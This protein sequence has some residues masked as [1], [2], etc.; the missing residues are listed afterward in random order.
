MSKS[1]NKNRPGSKN[2]PDNKEIT[3]E[4][5]AMK[6]KPYSKGKGKAQGTGTNLQNETKGTNKK[7]EAPVK[8]SVI[9]PSLNV[10]DYIDECISSVINQTLKDIEII[11][12]D[13]GSTDG[14]VDILRK[15]ESKD[16]RICILSSKKKSYG[17]Q[18][19]LGFAAARGEYVAIVET[20]DYIKS[21]MYETLYALAKEKDLDY[22]K[23]NFARFK[24]PEKSRIFTHSKIV[25]V[26]FYDRVLYAGDEQSVFIT[27][28]YPWAGIYRRSMI[29]DNNIRLNETPGASYQDNGLVFQVYAYGQRGYF[30]DKEFYYLRRED[31]DASFYAPHKVDEIFKEFDFVEEF[32]VKSGYYSIFA[33]R[34]WK[35]KYSTFCWRANMLA[36]EHKLEFM[37]KFADEFRKADQEGRLVTKFFDKNEKAYLY[38]IMACPDMV[39]WKKYYTPESV[40]PKLALCKEKIELGKERTSISGKKI[41]ILTNEFAPSGA[42][43]SALAQSK[44]LRDA[45]AYVEA[46]SLRDGE[47]RNNYEEEG[48]KTRIV[49]ASDYERTYHQD[50]IK[51]FDLAIMNTVLALPAA[52]VCA[53]LIPTILYIRSDGELIVH[54]FKNV[55]VFKN[56]YERYYTIKNADYVVAVSDF[57]GDWVRENLN[58]NVTVINN[59]LEDKFEEFGSRVKSVGST[60]TIKFLALGTI[61]K[62]KGYDVYLDAYCSLPENYRKRCEV[63]FAGRQLTGSTGFYKEITEKANKTAG[64]IFH[65]EILDRDKLYELILDSDVIVV[66]SR[67][68]SFS[69]VAIEGAMLGKP[70]ILT[71]DVGAKFLVENGK[72][73]WIVKTADVKSLAEAFKSA[74]DNSANLNQMGTAARKVYL[75]NCTVE[76]YSNN[77][78]K[79]VERVLY[80]SEKTNYKARKGAKLYSF[81]VFDTLVTRTVATPIGLFLIVQ[82][83]LNTDDWNDLPEHFRQNFYGLRINAER[84]ARHVGKGG[85]FEKFNP[86]YSE[87]EDITFDEIYNV[88]TFSGLLTDEQA[89]RVKELEIQTEIE[90]TVAISRNIELAKDLMKNGIRVIAL[91]DMYHSSKVIRQMLKAADPELENIPVYVSSEMLM[92]KRTGNAFRAVAKE[93]KVNFREWHHIGDNKISDFEVPKQLGIECSLYR[94]SWPS[95][96]ESNNLGLC[97]NDIKLQ[98]LAALAKN[99]RIFGNLYD[100]AAIGAS[101]S[102]YLLMPYIEFIIKTCEQRKIKRLYFIARDGYVLKLMADRFIEKRRLD[103]TTK[104]VYGSR[105][106]LRVF[107]ENALDIDVISILGASNYN[108]INSLEKL[109]EFFSITVPELCGYLPDNYKNIDTIDSATLYKI[110]IVLNNEI[111]FKKLISKAHSHKRE[112]LVRYLKQEIDCSDPGYAFVDLDCTGYTN[113]CMSKVLYDALDKKSPVKT[114][115]YWAINTK[116]TDSTHAF[117]SFFPSKLPK[118][119]I[120]ECLCRAPHSQ[121][122]GYEERDGK[123]ETI[124]DDNNEGEVLMNEGYGEYIHGVMQ[125][126]DQYL[127]DPVDISLVSVEKAFDYIA[128]KPDKDTLEFLGDIVFEASGR[129]NEIKRFAPALTYDDIFNV[130]FKRHI[131]KEPVEKYFA[132]SYFDYSLL[133]CTQADKNLIEYY[134]KLVAEYTKNKKLNTLTEDELVEIQ[135]KAENTV[136][137]LNRPELVAL[138]KK[139][140]APAA[141]KPAPKPAPVAPKPAPAAP[142]P[143]PAA[144][145]PAPNPPAKPNPNAADQALKIINELKLNRLDKLEKDVNMLKAELQQKEDLRMQIV[146]IRAS[147][148]Y[149]LGLAI[150]WLPRKIRGLFK[151]NK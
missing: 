133:R 129:S 6:K 132:V 125:A 22:I 59:F 123:I 142:K 101:L 50:L 150:T 120:I 60:D 4:E 15:Y 108:F 110:A 57:C 54:F 70:V 7:Y 16:T 67:S 143:A 66:P 12:V 112:I 35:L 19:N 33:P 20:D 37:Q 63:H 18:V 32:L 94:I 138:I 9:M 78:I 73:G 71:E 93:E 127:A 100:K 48:I 135:L 74:V 83:K 31:Q 10:A 124:F 14:T 99:A 79:Y 38:N 145:K 77:F 47:L 26:P 28:V 43:L 144:P 75:E 109:A 65:G 113:D 13:A 53:K 36:D 68:E 45:G 131:A 1:A 91:S 2:K 25:D 92:T 118:G 69:R 52:N 41:L 40:W 106:A 44:V 56:N 34:F 141:P 111:E 134:N 87:R 85:Y 102:M 122:S 137:K 104:Y 121:V 105:K 117:I 97:N 21:D 86:N 115:F 17:Y 5:A 29:V 51:Q 116:L 49:Y 82:Q 136:L 107:P 80:N 64:C 140:P 114:I 103:I 119:S 24:G 46:W 3:K 126:V 128:N 42:Q 72:N 11:C 147:F 8:V 96:V 89:E 62:R 30:V 130:Y 23:G 27:S 146:L 95:G 76:A 98:K 55:E 58:P 39:C 81:D 148:S 88:F 139:K 84:L 151:K 90:N 149:K 61:E